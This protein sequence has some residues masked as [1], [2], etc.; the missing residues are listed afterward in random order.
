MPYNYSKLER[1]IKEVFGTIEKFA[2]AVGLSMRSVSLKLN[3]EREW[4]QS[5]IDRACEVLGISK[6]EI[7]LYFFALN[8]QSY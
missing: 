6:N 4:K 8:V 2:K 1:K 3:G 5:Q 7:P